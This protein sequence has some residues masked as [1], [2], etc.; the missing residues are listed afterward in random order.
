MRSR[1]GRGGAADLCSQASHCLWMPR[2]ENSLIGKSGQ[3]YGE[4]LK[5]RDSGRPSLRLVFGALTV[6]LL[7][8]GLV[9]AARSWVFD[10]HCQGELEQ[11]LEYNPLDAF[12]DDA[13]VWSCRGE[14]QH[15]LEQLSRGDVLSVVDLFS[16]SVQCAG[17]ASVVVSS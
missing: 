11:Q 14:R 9:S 10:S 1:R 7:R 13:P 5:L 4:G 6:A 16:S 15:R 17:I 2:Q 12:Y 8:V 3:S